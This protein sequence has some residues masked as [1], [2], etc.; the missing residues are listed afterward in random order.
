MQ[1]QMS[2]SEF[3]WASTPHH[4]ELFRQSTAI[5]IAEGAKQVMFLRHSEGNRWFRACS[6]NLN[7]EKGGEK[8]GFALKGASA[9]AA[10]GFGSRTVT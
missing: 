7:P 6:K 8:A 5:G 4:V 10:K 1:S 3:K 9:H 2:E